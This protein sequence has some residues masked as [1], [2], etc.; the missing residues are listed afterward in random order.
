MLQIWRYTG[1]FGLKCAVN[2]PL[3]V[4]SR[5]NTTSKTIAAITL[6]NCYRLVVR[7]FFSFQ[8]LRENRRENTYKYNEIGV[9]ITEF[10][11]HYA[12]LVELGFSLSGRKNSFIWRFILLT[13]FWIR[14]FIDKT[15]QHTYLKIVQYSLNDL[16]KPMCV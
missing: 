2:F 13:I 3:G 10:I 7:V 15:T 1:K 12:C 8:F 5:K 11:D 9:W 4:C 14:F 6:Y 16:K